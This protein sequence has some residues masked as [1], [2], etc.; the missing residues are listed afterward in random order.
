MA[1]VRKRRLGVALAL[2]LVALPLSSARA[3][4]F[5]F[6][7]GA[8]ADYFGGSSD[9]HQEFNKNWGFGLEM[10]INLS[11]FALFAE[12]V[13]LGDQQYLFDFNIGAQFFPVETPV[14]FGIGIYTGPLLF[15]FQA[16][17]TPTGLDFSGLSSS[18]EQ[19]L[20]QLTGLPNLNVLSARFDQYASTT[21]DLSRLAFGWNIV[22]GRLSLDVP[23]G[24]FYIGVAGQIAYHYFIS[25]EGIAAGAKNE[26]IDEFVDD[27]DIP[28]SLAESLRDV[29]GAK[30]IEASDLNGFNWDVNFYITVEL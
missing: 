26:A 16:P 20:L 6:W 17:E 29:V 27:Y 10:G 9:V 7:L 22:R 15:L 21:E 4:A 18:E 23:V 14:R 8:R 19:A 25:G 24:P 11:F 5:R 12:T 2:L 30:A 13:F 1:R 28:S 3:D